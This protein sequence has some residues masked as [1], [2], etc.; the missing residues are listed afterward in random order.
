MQHCIMP[1]AALFLSKRTRT[2]IRVLHTSNYDHKLCRCRQIAGKAAT[3]PTDLRGE[4]TSACPYGCSTTCHGHATSKSIG[5]RHGAGIEYF[6]HLITGSGDAP[7]A[8]TLLNPTK[9]NRYL[10]GTPEITQGSLSKRKKK[11]FM[12]PKSW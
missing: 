5:R 6:E 11:E 8:S 10:R 4:C 2:R 1:V 7:P 3:I 12:F 9:V